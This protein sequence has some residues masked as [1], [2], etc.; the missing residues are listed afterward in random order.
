MAGFF[1]GLGGRLLV[2]LCA[3]SLVSCASVIE[4]IRKAQD[5]G[6]THKLRKFLEDERS[7]VRERTLRAFEHT[8]APTIVED[9]KFVKDFLIACLT[10]P[11]EK[12]WVKKECAITIA[13]WRMEQAVDDL[14]DGYA[15]MDD[16]DARFWMLV[17]L[18][19]FE[20]ARIRSVLQSATDD[21]DFYVS[22]LARQLVIEGKAMSIPSIQP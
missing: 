8:G 9:E 17:A 11:A 15:A 18:S 20:G 14:A 16:A 10:D 5:A 7:F 19:T 4:D 12:P 6:D 13:T 2:V 21:P 3:L 1:R 22:A